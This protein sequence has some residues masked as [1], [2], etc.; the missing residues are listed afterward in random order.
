MIDF[1]KAQFDKKGYVFND[2]D[3]TYV[4]NIFV[5]RSAYQAPN[6][7]NDFLYVVYKDYKGDWRIHQWQIVSDYLATI[8]DEEKITGS[9]VIAPGQYV[10]AYKLGEHASL[11]GKAKMAFVQQLDKVNTT[12]KEGNLE[13]GY[14]GC[15]IITKPDRDTKLKSSVISFGNDHFFRDFMKL[16][17]YSKGFHGNAFTLTVF[18][19]VDFDINNRFNA[20]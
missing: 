17:H 16:L 9:R 2:S 14:Y 19:E 6:T 7:E 3:V 18:D 11:E 1:I 13:R 10:G 5:V 4:L 20:A 8:Q 15:D 12:T